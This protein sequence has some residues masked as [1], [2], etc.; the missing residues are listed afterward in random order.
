MVADVA[1]GTHTFS[2]NV[3]E[4]AISVT[5]TAILE[6][7]GEAIIGVA[8]TCSQTVI[9]NSSVVGVAAA[10]IDQITTDPVF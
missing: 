9:Q 8:D 5:D 4:V 10:A 2:I 6:V 3:L 7:A 1:L